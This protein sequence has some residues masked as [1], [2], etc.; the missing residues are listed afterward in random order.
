[1]ADAR[2]LL[3]PVRVYGRR[4]HKLASLPILLLAKLHVISPRTA[5]CWWIWLARRMIRV[6]IGDR[7][8]QRLKFENACTCPKR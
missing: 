6:K 3:L 1:M 4:R 8:I 7:P 2:Q 5:Y